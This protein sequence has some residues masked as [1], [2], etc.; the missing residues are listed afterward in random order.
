MAQDR[1]EES[2]FLT[3][4][5]N[6][7]H[8]A[9]SRS[10]IH[11]WVCAVVI[12]IFLMI[13]S[14]ELGRARN[15][16][17]P[18]ITTTETT[19][20]AAAAPP[21]A[22]AVANCGTTPEDAMEAGCSFDAML[23]AWVPAHCFNETLSR[24]FLRKGGTTWYKDPDRTR[25]VRVSLVETGRFMD[26]WVS[27]NYP[28]ERCLYIWAKITQTRDE[29]DPAQAPWLSPEI[30][31]QCAETFANFTRDG[32]LVGEMRLSMEFLSC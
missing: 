11:A 18:C 9:C 22:A 26:V 14:Y 1:E 19:T 5:K 31:A 10:K 15:A 12:T 21:A 25:E 27:G 32:G 8:T 16:A 24:Q 17:P 2:P 6:T 7:R 30:A 4:E 23:Y 28:V 20:S 29:G 13:A 3:P